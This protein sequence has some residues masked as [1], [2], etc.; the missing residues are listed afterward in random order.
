M[1]CEL[2]MIRTVN[3]DGTSHG[4]FQWPLEVGAEVI[5]PDWN[6]EPV[7]GGGLHGL[8]MGEGDAGLMSTSISA[9]VLV[10]A[11]RES[12][13]VWELVLSYQ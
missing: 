4:G 2:Y 5:A 10:C 3:T 12:E 6:P 11:V 13:V 7:C 1:A 9:T 8:L